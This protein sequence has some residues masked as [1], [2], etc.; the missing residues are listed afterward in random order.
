MLVTEAGDISQNI[1]ETRKRLL[2]AALAHVPFDGWSHATLATAAAEAGVSPA[3]ARAAFPRGGVDM[4]LAFH[5][6]GDAAMVERLT[7]TDLSGLR[8]RDRIATAVRFRL[9][10]VAEHKE[11]VRRGATLFAL[12][13]YAPEAASAVWKTA[14]AIWTALGDASADHSWYTKRA[15]LAGVI[16]S[17]LLYWLGDDSPD[18]AATWEF[19]DRR[20]ENVMTFEQMKGKFLAT[21]L[22]RM[23]E[24][25]PLRLL[26]HIRAPD[27][28]FRTTAPGWIRR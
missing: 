20:I 13:V 14:D 6:R 19:L 28:S 11:A 1:V 27:P 22:G 2:D 5:R 24:K 3:V 7:H 4:A 17:T 9:E 26:D 12:P 8:F 25:G 23:M 18:S 16:S 10:A 15:T 21:P